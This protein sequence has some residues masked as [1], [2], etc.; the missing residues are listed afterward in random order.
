[1]VWFGIMRMVA[2]VTAIGLVQYVRRRIDTT[3]HEAL[4]RLLLWV[5]VLQMT[6]LLVFALTREFVSGMAAYLTATNLHRMFQPLYLALLNLHVESTVRATVI[7]MSRQVDSLGQVVGAT[8]LGA[9]GSLVSIQAAL[10]AT[11]LTLLP[12]IGLNLRARGQHDA[13]LADLASV[14][15]CR[16]HVVSCLNQSADARISVGGP[17]VC[18]RRFYTSW[19]IHGSSS[20]RS[21]RLSA[22]IF[23]RFH[24]IAG[25]KVP[26][27]G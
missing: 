23:C 27:S 22:D 21:R 14:N 25:S 9:L 24:R 10:A 7:S 13:Q 19:P 20:G 6:S 16:P 5:N 17:V 18:P 1:V 8:L 4:T 11:A 12:A 2:A 26:G 15:C 3:N